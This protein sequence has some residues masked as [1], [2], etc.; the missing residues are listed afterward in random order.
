MVEFEFLCFSVSRDLKVFK[1][2]A[3]LIIANRMQAKLQDVAE[4]V[5]TRYL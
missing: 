1:N 5:C 3:D 2:K 4:K